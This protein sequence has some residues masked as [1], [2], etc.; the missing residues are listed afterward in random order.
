MFSYK[1]LL[2]L[3]VLKDKKKKANNLSIYHLLLAVA[4]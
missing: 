1:S 3:K 2:N 4:L